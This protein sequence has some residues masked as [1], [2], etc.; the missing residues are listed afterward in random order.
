[1]NK[2]QQLDKNYLT[3][4]GDVLD[5]ICWLFYGSTANV[6]ER[7]LARNPVL[8]KYP[9]V[10]PAGIILVLPLFKYEPNRVALWDY[11][12]PRSVDF[13]KLKQEEEDRLAAIQRYRAPDQT[14][15]I[16]Q[17]VNSLYSPVAKVQP[18]LVGNQVPDSFN[19]P[20]S[21]VMPG[22][23]ADQYV[24]VYYRGEGNVFKVGFVKREEVSPTEGGTVSDFLITG[25]P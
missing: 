5:R 19:R 16:G 20:P 22:E 21:P 23:D 11:V 18:I 8:N 6:T 15:F 3:S 12:Q 10:L 24:A 25:S 14:I 4:D 2:I 1:M 7:V 9:S 13:V 17:S